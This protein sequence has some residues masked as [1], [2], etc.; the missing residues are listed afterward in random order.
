MLG[1][2]AE[3]VLIV[4]HV[5]AGKTTYAKKLA[6]ATGAVRLTPDEWMVP[7]FGHHDPDGMRDVVEGRL[8][9]T[10]VE[11]LRAGASVILDF[12][13]WGRDE[14]A[15]LHWLAAMVGAS[16]RTVYLPVG[17]EEQAG[18]VWKRWRETPEQTWHVTQADLDEW[19]ELLHEPDSDELAGRYAPTPSTGGGW[20]DWISKRWP[21]ALERGQWQGARGRNE[22]AD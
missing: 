15:S 6:T 11:I 13:F 5:G 9:W 7:L 19:R 2:V 10:A 3:L 14:R 17:R 20:A 12:G 1:P 18:R 21:T 16:A 22:T 8:I 4:G